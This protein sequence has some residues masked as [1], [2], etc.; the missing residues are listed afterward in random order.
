MNFIALEELI[1]KDLELRIMNHRYGY[2]YIISLLPY[3]YNDFLD[4][5]CEI[6]CQITTENALIEKGIPI[7]A[8]NSTNEGIKKVCEVAKNIN[9]EK[10]DTIMSE[11]SQI[12]NGFEIINY[13]DKHTLL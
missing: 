4:L 8:C 1:D 9:I 10:L 3:G 5:F 13:L 12:K 6:Y 2:K 7:Y 11:L